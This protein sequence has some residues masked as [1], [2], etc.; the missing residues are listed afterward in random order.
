ML[1]LVV[2]DMNFQRYASQ[3]NG[4]CGGPKQGKARRAGELSRASRVILRVLPGRGDAVSADSPRK[5]IAASRP[6][7]GRNA[8]DTL[9]IGLHDTP[10]NLIK[11]NHTLHRSAAT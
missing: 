7:R 10:F 8:I 1:G 6:P 3:G 9:F 2:K 11:I 5:T 4:K